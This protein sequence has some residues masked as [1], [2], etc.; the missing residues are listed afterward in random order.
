MRKQKKRNSKTKKIK[1]TKTKI[2]IKNCKH[3]Q[4]FFKRIK[5]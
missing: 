4:L 1:K 5:L 3:T 2:N